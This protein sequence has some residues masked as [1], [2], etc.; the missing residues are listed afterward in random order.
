[1]LTIVSVCNRLRNCL[2]TDVPLQPPRLSLPTTKHHHLTVPLGDRHV[3]HL[4]PTPDVLDRLDRQPPV[5][6]LQLIGLPRLI[7]RSLDALLHTKL[8]YL[9]QTATAVG[10][11]QDNLDLLPVFLPPP[12]LPNWQISALTNS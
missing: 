9:W 12:T 2:P 8:P 6:R 4:K 10:I 1:M 7:P 5:H 3:P 11:Q